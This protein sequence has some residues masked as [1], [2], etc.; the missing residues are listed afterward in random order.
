M[1][2]QRRINMTNWK[3]I[4]LAT[5]L[6]LFGMTQSWADTVTIQP[7]LQSLAELSTTAPATRNLT[8]QEWQTTKGSKVLF[9]A[10]PE[11]P[12][13]DI[14]LTFAA[15]SSRD[16]DKPGIA[17]FTNAMLNEGVKGKDV[18]AIA[19]TF[20]NVGA[21]YGNG[22]YRDMAIITLRSL[23]DKTKRQTALAMFTQILAEPTFPASSFTRIK[24]QLLTGFEIQKKT[25]SSLL[26]NEFYSR[27]Y[28]NHPYAHPKEGDRTSIKAITIADL[29]A[30]YQQAYSAKNVVI[31][32]VGDLSKQEA[33]NMAEQISKALPQGDKLDTTMP[34]EQPKA[35]IYHIDFSSE[36]THIA[37][38]QLGVTRNNPDFAALYLG[39]QILGG[40]T[41]NSRLMT[42]VRERRGL[43]YGIYSEFATMQAAGLFKIGL[44]T[45]AEMTEGCLTLIK[46][47]VDDYLKTGP[48]EKEVEDAKKEIIGSFPLSNASNAS[49]VGQLGV[50]GFYH[51]PHDY[52]VN[53]VKQIQ[54][55]TPEQVK[56]AM[57][58]HL[59]MDDFIVVTVGPTVKQMA[60]PAPT[61][62]KQAA[63]GVPEH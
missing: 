38:G 7:K 5:Q 11:L 27:L 54:S 48:T 59:K 41:L 8:I 34:P 32:L 17:L 28:G 4:F 39:N 22:S 55:L 21:I 62:V 10:A 58:K 37:M 43:T 35:G 2:Y 9:V 12:M 60:I 42:E 50:I 31:A 53:F 23:T 15:G 16:G 6:G 26:N 57:N 45:R 29:K 44:Q 49:I 13:F 56:I 30:F 61:K 1:Y 25:A 46:Q 18:V 40:G 24:N 19:K 63:V 51:L 47:L 52:L 36:Q 3:K 33:M 14:Q 20:E